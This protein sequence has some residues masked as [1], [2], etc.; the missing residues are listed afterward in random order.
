MHMWLNVQLSKKT[1]QGESYP[2][3]RPMSP[4][5]S[6]QP[7]MKSGRMRDVHDIN[8]PQSSDSE[9][10]FEGNPVEYLQ[11]TWK[12][13]GIGQS[14]Y[15]NVEELARVCEHIGMDMTE[16]VSFCI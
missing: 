9:H 4:T 10:S 2:S 6:Q 15:L 12:K 13:L 8:S 11:D 3:K 14:G 16:E 1:F 7:P 5:D